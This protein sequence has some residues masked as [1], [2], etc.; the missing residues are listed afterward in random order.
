MIYLFLSCRSNKCLLRWSY[1]HLI[2]LSTVPNANSMSFIALF[3]ELFENLTISFII[4][5][6]SLK[7]ELVR[8]RLSLCICANHALTVLT[9]VQISGSAPTSTRNSY[10][11]LY[12]SPWVSLSVGLI[13]RSLYPVHSQVFLVLQV[14][15]IITIVPPLILVIQ[16]LL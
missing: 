13:S 5:F 1:L 6:I 16:A 11:L 10:Y 7:L 15:F 4:F 14:L 9:S 12:I 8:E 3:S 2:H